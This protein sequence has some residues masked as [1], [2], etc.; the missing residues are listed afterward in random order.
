MKDTLK[1]KEKNY[2]IEVQRLRHAYEKVKSRWSGSIR[3]S[4]RSTSAA[5][6][7]QSS[8]SKN[9]IQSRQS[10]SKDI[11]ILKD[12]HSKEIKD[13]KTRLQ[14]APRTCHFLVESIQRYERES[15][16]RNQTARYTALSA[17]RQQIE[18]NKKLE[19]L[20]VEQTDTIASLKLECGNVK[21]SKECSTS[22]R[23]FSK[24]DILFEETNE[25]KDVGMQTENERRPSQSDRE[26]HEILNALKAMQETQIQVLKTLS[27][28]TT[29]RF[30]FSFR[31]MQNGEENKEIA[32]FQR[33][34][35]PFKA[36]SQNT[37]PLNIPRQIQTDPSSI[38]TSMAFI[39]IVFVRFHF[40]K[41][42][43][44]NAV[45]FKI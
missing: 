14:V 18:K 7:I 31:W 33:K 36:L 13:L 30:Q 17:L 21:T 43:I 25:Q 34:I 42:R 10:S 29:S 20:V 19:M 9:H 16:Q 39:F 5:N 2:E 22:P 4:S 23:R 40:R 44:P 45:H 35:D 41:D 8:P 38:V 24:Y 11:Q 37:N 15:S 27:S 28:R 6:V 1:E 26:W 3:K 32:Y 12:Q